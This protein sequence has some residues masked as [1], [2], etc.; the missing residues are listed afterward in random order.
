MSDA[1][2]RGRLIR[3]AH[4]R[5]DLRPHILPILVDR[6]ASRSASSS[7]DAI[8]DILRS[9]FRYRR[10]PDAL[11]S[12]KVLAGIIARHPDADATTFK[13][14]IERVPDDLFGSTV[15][16]DSPK[17]DLLRG[18][19]K[20]PEL[21]GTRSPLRE[22][23][24]TLSANLETLGF[25]VTPP[26]FK[27]QT[28]LGAVFGVRDKLIGHLPLGD[29]GLFAG[30]EVEVGVGRNGGFLNQPN[31]WFWVS[32]NH[33]KIDRAGVERVA[34]PLLGW[35]TGRHATPWPYF[36][37]DDVSG[38]ENLIRLIRKITVAV[39][40]DAPQIIAQFNDL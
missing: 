1:V 33:G 36:E 15:G 34:E 9:E 26:R 19:R 2:L 14:E 28:G 21:L 12:A 22:A 40:A 6:V 7:M 17:Y 35:S 38:L 37:A 8:V 29:R 23:V 3:L 31:A 4:S 18:Y 25:V 11:K 24:A 39:K 20:L 30:I 32:D 27:S 10:K 5:P 16:S 13:R